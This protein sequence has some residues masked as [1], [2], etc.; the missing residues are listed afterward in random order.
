[1][2]RLD[3]ALSRF[4]HKLPGE[5]YFGLFRFQPFFFLLGAV[6]EFSMIK[7]E[8]GQKKHNFYKTYK[9]ARA[10]EYAEKELDEDADF[11]LLRKM[12]LEKLK[13]T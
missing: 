6:V 11:A 9:P 12:M 5:K 10:R 3:Y 2:T 7:W 8:A 13:K 4:L 1:M